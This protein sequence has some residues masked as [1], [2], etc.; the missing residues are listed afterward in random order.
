MRL[1][2]V[3][4]VPT[5]S[6]PT[7]FNGRETKANSLAQSG[8]IDMGDAVLVTDATVRKVQA[9]AGN[10]AIGVRGVV[11]GEP[12]GRKENQDLQKKKRTGRKRIL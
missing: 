6:Q 4:A 8:S 11:R 2:V 3:L 12:F 9:L 7:S 1:T 10:V 5:H